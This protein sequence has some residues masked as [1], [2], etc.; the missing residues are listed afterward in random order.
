MTAFLRLSVCLTALALLFS[1]VGCSKSG[2]ETTPPP[3]A[4]TPQTGA[5]MY[6]TGPGATQGQPAASTGD[7]GADA[8][9]KALS[10]PNV[11][12][13]VKEQIRQ[14]MGGR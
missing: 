1:L 7:P 10:D 4:N 9:N 3:A 14:Q 5:S 2:E 6:P 13:N 8:R 12:A 11:P